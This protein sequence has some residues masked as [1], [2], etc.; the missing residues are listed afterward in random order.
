MS[1]LTHDNFP[2]WMFEQPWDTLLSYITDARDAAVQIKLK[3]HF[4]MADPDAARMRIKS[5]VLDKS[6]SVEELAE[7]INE[8]IDMLL[9][10][11]ESLSQFRAAVIQHSEM[12]EHSD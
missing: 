9:Q 3:T 4:L 12:R 8:Q 11:I 10:T 1:E 6:Q 7:N 5:P 2:Q